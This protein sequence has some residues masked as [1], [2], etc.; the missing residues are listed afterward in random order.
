MATGAFEVRGGYEALRRYEALRGAT[1]Y[2][3]S[4]EEEDGRAS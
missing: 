3:M 4:Y 1:S 2:N